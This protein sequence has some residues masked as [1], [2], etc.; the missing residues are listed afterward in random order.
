MW[1]GFLLTSA[2]LYSSSWKAVCVPFCL[3]DITQAFAFLE[4]TAH[5]GSSLGRTGIHSCPLIAGSSSCLLIWSH[6]VLLHFSVPLSLSRTFVV[7][8]TELLAAGSPGN[9]A[10]FLFLILLIA[11]L[12]P[13][14]CWLA[15]S[16]PFIWSRPFSVFLS[17]TTP[18][19]C[20]LKVN[21]PGKDKPTTDAERV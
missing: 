12:D 9:S 8:R 14:K 16:A 17:S 15:R 6:P 7:S 5:I 19:S 21:Y 2:S 18:C 11:S 1:I 10:C 3:H 4:L 13:T 20:D